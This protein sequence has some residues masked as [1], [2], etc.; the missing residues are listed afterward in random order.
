MSTALLL[1]SPPAPLPKTARL[2]SWGAQV[3]AAVLLA[4][5]LFF[6]FSGAAETV[7]IFGTL[8]VEPFGRYAA[9]ISELIAVVLLLRSRTAFL[10]GLLTLGIM[11]GAIAAHLGPL[12][13]EVLGDGGLLF[14][15]AIVVFVAAALVTF[16]R[17]PHAA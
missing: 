8:G 17:R 12:G 16:L 10:G 6:K 5:T 7:H 2:V 14:A 4:Q 9:G 1:L 3:V 13:I 11:A 15:L